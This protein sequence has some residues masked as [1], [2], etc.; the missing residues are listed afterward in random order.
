ML[1]TRLDV[2]DL[3]YIT[4]YRI[5]DDVVFHVHVSRTPAAETVGR[6]LDTFLDIFLDYNV[7]V[8]QRRQEAL[9]ASAT[10]SD[11]VDAAAVIFC[12]LENQLIAPTPSITAPPE[13]ER[14]V[15]G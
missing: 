6:H 9:S 13:T 4:Y 1:P 11:S 7:A 2:M 8:D 3:N 10:Y 12:T 14:R 5:A 15:S